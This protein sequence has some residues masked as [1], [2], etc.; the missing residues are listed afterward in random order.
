MG[1]EVRRVPAGWAHPKDEKGRWIPLLK[2]SFVQHDADWN[3]QYAK[4][5]DGLVSDYET[6]GW[7]P[8]PPDAPYRMKDWYGGGRPDPDDYMPAWS[9][10][11]RTHW[12]MY[13][14]VSEGTPISPV[15]ETP[16]A[17]ARWLAD[18]KA[19]AAA[20]RT[21][22]YAQ[23]L[24]TIRVGGAPSLVTGRHGL[25]SG[26]EFVGGVDPQGAAP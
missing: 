12:Q 26:V 19:D 1:R 17:L 15:M 18:S 11:E 2:G 10:A 7:K 13:E 25:V 3:E 8:K 6:R 14:N 16:E 4:W 22:S 24:A 5:R 9:K 21:A 20:G 23:W